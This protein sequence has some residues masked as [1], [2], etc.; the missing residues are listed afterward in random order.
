[1]TKLVLFF[2][3]YVGP[4]QRGGKTVTGY[5]NKRTARTKSGNGQLVM[6]LGAPKEPN[7]EDVDAAIRTASEGIEKLDRLQVYHVLDKN[8][9][10][11]DRLARHISAKRPDLAEEVRG[12]MRDLKR[13]DDA[14]A[15]ETKTRISAHENAAGNHERAAAS[16]SDAALKQGHAAAASEHRRAAEDY[17]AGKH[18]EANER[19][20][21]TW[22][23]TR[24][25]QSKDPGYEKRGE[26]APQK[27]FYVTIVREPGTKAQK[28]GWLAGPFDSQD[29]AEKHVPAAR[30]KASELDPY[31]DFDAFGVTSREAKTHP[32]GVLNKHLKIGS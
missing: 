16:T 14:D 1:M 21:P 6:T 26:D 31:S 10:L 8:P 25:M 20:V 27:K 7:H 24:E 5:D 22:N 17:R 18:R 28:V 4:Y 2:K 9:A 12:S 3:S 13:L 19:F 15:A 30:K 32:P 11:R 23:K 29:E